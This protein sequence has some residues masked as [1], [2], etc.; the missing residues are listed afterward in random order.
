MRALDQ[1]RRALAERRQRL[2]GLGD[3]LAQTR[4]GAIGAENI[5]HRGFAGAR[6][7]AGLFA[8]E[9]GVAFD[10]EKIVGDL[11]GLAHGRPVAL[12]DSRSRG[13]EA[14]YELAQEYMDRNKVVSPKAEERKAA[15]AKAEAEGKSRKT[16]RFWP[17]A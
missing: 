4:L 11:E 16:V 7:L 14:Y 2:L 12:Y 10:V 1:D 6:V 3:K 9:C 13:A 5:D 17:Y 8:D 15:A